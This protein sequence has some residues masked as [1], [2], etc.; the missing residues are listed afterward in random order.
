MVKYPLIGGLDLTTVKPLVK[1]GSLKSCLNFEVS[2]ISGYTRIGGVAR[3]DG[4]EDVGGYKIWRLKYS[5]A[6][7]A[8]AFSAGD[9]VWFDPTYTGVVLQV[10]TGES[11]N[12]VYVLMPE[13]AASPSLPADL[14]SA[15][16]TISILK[17][18]AVFDG[19]GTQDQFDAAIQSIES[20]QRERITAVPGRD[21]SDIIGGFWYKD[22]LYVIRDLPR[23]GFEGGY[24][25]DADEG[26]TITLNGQ[27]F[28]IL[29]VSITGDNIGVL[30]YDT[31]ATGTGTAA[32]P[33]GDATLVDL[34][35]T[36]DYGD[37]YVG[38]PYSDDLD[39]SGG[40]PPYTWALAGEKGT[41]LDPVDTVDANAINFVPQLTNAALY[42]SGPAGWE[43]VSLGRELRFKNGTTNL[44][45]FARSA[46]LTGSA[47]LDTG[48]KYP[49]TATLNG[50]AATHLAADDGVDD[51]LQ[52]TSSGYNE[53]LVSH[54]DLSAIPATAS[55]QGIEVLVDRHSNTA[56]PA[57]DVVVSLIGV[58]GGTENKA[59]GT[60]W[61]DTAAAVSYG[62]DTDLW[63]S[64]A[65]TGATVAASTFGVRLLVG[66]A[67][68]AAAIG[69]VD[70]IQ[71][72]VHYIERES[73]VYV[74]DGTT[75][76]PFTLHHT[77]I[78]SGDTSSSTAEGYMTVS[79][80]VNLDKPRLVN[81]G[82]AIRTGPG[83]TGNLLG[84]AAARDRP[85]WL[86]GQAEIDNNR[87]RYEFW[88]TNFYG[89]DQFEAVFGVCGAS[90]AFSFDGTRF[91]RIRAELPADLDLPRHVCRHGDMLCL[92]YFP[93]AVA[94]SKPGD[95]FELRGAQGANAVEVGDRLTGLIPL[96][97]DALGIICQSMTQ[98]IR[99][100]TPD[101]M[102]KSPISLNR[103]GIEYTAVD[104][105]RIV[106]CDGLG[107]FLAD[108][109]ESFGAASRNYISQPVHPWLQPR[110]QAVANGESAFLRPV[111]ALSVRNKNQM[112]LYFWDGW[113]LTMTMNEPPEFTTQ[114]YYTPAP[115]AHTEPLPW[116]PRMLCSGLDSAGRERL[117]VSF[118]G[119]IKEGYVFEMDAGRTFDGDPIPAELE[120]NPLTVD[121]SA[122]EKRYDRLFLYGAGLG[123][124]SLTYSRRLND[125]DSITGLYPFKM[126]RGD[127]TA[128]LTWG[129]MRGSVD[130][131]IEG[132]DVSI[133][134][135]STSSSD[136]VFT[137]Q[138][139]E[140]FVNKRGNSRGGTGG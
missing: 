11:A 107:V 134:F 27:A 80:D 83:G 77:Q 12:V 88:R 129:A 57:K 97:G 45:N 109:P 116:T 25:T 29:D 101:T 43:R 38:V 20:G 50:V 32:S 121:S 26:K 89:Q 124:A 123:R 114:R 90:P 46:V 104:M 55:I 105:G 28:V 14:A 115:D 120:L 96:A 91:I 16:A 137:L 48:Y 110:L 60:A 68:G 79:G 140:H 8:S 9:I 63:G 31:T 85:L 24:Y 36:G 66:P 37:G 64:Q 93:G 71:I 100:T 103:G 70:R 61:P 51:S 19:Y 69:G 1:P 58:D 23:I 52:A 74:W 95:P 34:P 136:G 35:V 119:G 56:N 5:L 18:E 17:R 111:A 92:G 47:V 33:I 44:S 30:T 78:T 62:S 94:F 4:S 67:S 131:P 135:S 22:R 72:R 21:G 127:R 118:Y 65:I 53:Y 59:K 122:E 76:V 108:S 81:E 42:R 7:N 84:Y 138:Y 2:T 54:F 132:N 99:G 3:Y 113:V 130:Q 112:R 41:A 133:R 125:G 106:L 40:I 39:V 139:V 6:D 117:F 13:A 75:D 49:G 98:V 87:S 86:A 102:V 15:D 82:D 10:A 128:K 126:G 73:Q